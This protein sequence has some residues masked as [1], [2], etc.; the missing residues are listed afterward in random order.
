MQKQQKAKGINLREVKRLESENLNPEEI[1][2]IEALR[3]EH[4]DSGLY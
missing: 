3:K 1:N 4:K 2:I